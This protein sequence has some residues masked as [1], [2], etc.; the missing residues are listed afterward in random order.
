MEIKY[1]CQEDGKIKLMKCKIKMYNTFH[2]RTK[3]QKRIINKNNFT[4]RSLLE[5][6]EKYLYGA[7]TCL[8][9][10]CGAGAV[11][12]FVASRRKKVLG[13][14][15]SKVSIKACRE[16]ARRL[17]LGNVALFKVMNFPK[18][19]PGRRF[20]MIICSEVLEHIENDEKALEEIYHLLNSRG[21][22]VISVPSKNA[23]L[24]R[25]GLTKRFDVEVGHLRRYD[26]KQ[27]INLCERT[28]FN[29][30]ETRRS[31]G[32]LRNFLFLNP[33]GGKMI[34]FIRGPISDFVTALDNVTLKLFGESQIF[35]VA[36]KK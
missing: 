6:L 16:G 20:D 28:G 24:F 23:P 12:L 32:I 8:D 34:R 11:S 33:V 10:G 7:R 36:Q 29:I 30:L 9:I 35:V 25:V 15:I 4:Y 5:L 19:K 21:L 27:L 2:R 3:P 31:E 17:K 18:E 1:S 26:F 22:S 13:I 14:D